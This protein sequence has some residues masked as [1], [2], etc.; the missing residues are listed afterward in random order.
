M[1]RTPEHNEL[2]LSTPARAR[3][4]LLY[5]I[6]TGDVLLAAAV[7]QAALADHI[8]YSN[9]LASWKGSYDRAV[10]RIKLLPELPETV[11]ALAKAAP[12]FSFLVERH[13]NVQRRLREVQELA[14]ERFPGMPDQRAIRDKRLVF[15]SYVLWAARSLKTPVG[16]QH[17]VL[18][19]VAAKAVD[20]T[21]D[22]DEYRDR[23]ERWRKLMKRLKNQAQLFEAA[24]GRWP[25]PPNFTGK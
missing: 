18:L 23:L 10:A 3:A 25:V 13:E 8:H 17:L 5:L 2:H 9:Q 21:S 14:H 19:E 12:W 1:G 20:P 24:W 11:R 6:E 4:R 15:G 22:E 7:A 16:P